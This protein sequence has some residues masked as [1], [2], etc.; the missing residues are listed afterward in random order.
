MGTGLWHERLAD[1]GSGPVDTPCDSAY[2]ALIRVWCLYRAQTFYRTNVVTIRSLRPD[3]L[4]THRVFPDPGE[5]SGFCAL[6][7]RGARQ[8][9]GARAP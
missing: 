7:T 3:P 6:R 1:G 2:T 5:Q 8:V 4:E 9:T